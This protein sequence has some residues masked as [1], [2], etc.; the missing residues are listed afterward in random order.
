M[1]MGECGGVR[2]GGGKEDRFL[3]EIIHYSAPAQSP[4]KSVLW[5]TSNWPHVPSSLKWRTW[6]NTSFPLQDVNGL[7]L[8]LGPS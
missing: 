6:L 2:S 8:E 4:M 7:G 3:L 5:I 1:N